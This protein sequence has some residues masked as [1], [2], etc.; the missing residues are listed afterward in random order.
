MTQWYVKELS[1][2][3][4]VSS[5]TLH[6]Y[7]RIGLLEPSVR[8]ANGYRLYSEKDLL[9]L[10]QILALKFFGF[11]LAQIKV[12]LHKEVGM[13]D[14]LANQA[15]LLEEKANALHA[16]SQTL[17]N[18]TA[19]CSN[20]NSIPWE[21]IIKSIEVY[22][23]TQQLEKTWAGKVFT[24]HELKEYANFEQEIK[25]R[26]TLS[27]Q[28][29]LQQAW[30]NL[31]REVEDNLDK[32][33]SSEYG[34]MMGKRCMDWVNTYYGKKNVAL[35]NAI[36]D[37]GFK[38][39]KI[40]ENIISPEGFTWLD[41]AIS[42][43]YRNRIMDILGNVGIYSNDVVKQQWEEL[44]GD[45]YGDEADPK[46]EIFKVIL[47]DDKISKDSKDWLKKYLEEK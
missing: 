31:I 10:Q 34:L 38:Q 7:D 6:H 24:P 5:Q 26:F 16:A 44:L 30:E 19:D 21:T 3:T 32:N 27:E 43:Y 1:Q 29:A 41:N 22:R 20:N 14:H 28:Q 45:M 37:K 17:K 13:M 15:K 8:L 2:L 39:G 47:T 18:I 11:E 4:Q 33:P 36:W 46:D 40:E 42:A 9:K 23:M 25:K 35:R 12:L